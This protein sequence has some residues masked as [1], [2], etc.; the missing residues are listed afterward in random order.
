MKNGWGASS[1]I[2]QNNA[3][4][5]TIW[6][7]GLDFV[8][9]PYI[10][11]HTEAVFPRTLPVALISVPLP[12]LLRP[13]GAWW[14]MV[15]FQVAHWDQAD[16]ASQMSDAQG[17]LLPLHKRVLSSD[18]L[19]GPGPGP[20]DRILKHCSS[21]AFCGLCSSSASC[22]VQSSSSQSV[23]DDS[24][25]RMGCLSRYR[26]RLGSYLWLSPGLPITVL[27][28]VPFLAVLLDS[29]GLNSLHSLWSNMQ[30]LSFSTQPKAPHSPLFDLPSPP[31]LLQDN[32]LSV[33]LFFF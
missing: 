29:Q 1:Q 20:K 8:S 3:Y 14:W 9:K 27:S 31:S 10:Y 16:L 32:H 19:T 15:P 22:R 18:S 21:S 25:L 4:V 13:G 12:R 24:G 33:L 28:L 6:K 5:T 26:R 11:Y 2:L 17:C 7:F 23:W 30:P